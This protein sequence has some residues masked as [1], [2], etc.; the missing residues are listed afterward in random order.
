MNDE[1]YTISPYGLIAMEIG[2]EAARRVIDRLEL[3]LRRHY[4][5]P[6]GIV[7][8]DGELFFCKLG[9]PEAQET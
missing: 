7:L 8:D 2:T 6:A 5:S 4:G 9:V 1:V 3:H